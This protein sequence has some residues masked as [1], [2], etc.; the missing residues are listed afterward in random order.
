MCT[1]NHGLVTL[2]ALN[3]TCNM[4][5]LQ[6]WKLWNEGEAASLADTNV[7]DES[8]AKEITKCVQIGLLCVQEVANDRPNVSTVIWMLTTENTNLKKPKQPA[9]IGRR[10]A[11]EAESSDQSSQK[12][13]IN[14]VS[15]TAVT[16]R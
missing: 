13:S 14:D 9:I 8:F 12:V 11:S 1:N 4:V 6:A 2:L 3:L 10:G 16:G 5:F 7:F 15:L